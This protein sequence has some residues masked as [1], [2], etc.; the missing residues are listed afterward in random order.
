MRGKRSRPGA[1]QRPKFRDDFRVVGREWGLLLEHFV[2]GVICIL[3]ALVMVVA[4]FREP[5]F[6]AASGPGNSLS[7]FHDD[8]QYNRYEE[9]SCGTA[10]QIWYFWLVTADKTFVVTSE[11]H[12]IPT[13]WVQEGCIWTIVGGVLAGTLELVWIAG[14]SVVGAS[15]CIRGFVAATRLC[16]K[17]SREPKAVRRLVR[18]AYEGNVNAASALLNEMTPTPCP[19]STEANA[20]KAMVNRRDAYGRT[21]IWAAAVGQ[22]CNSAEVARLLLKHGADPNSVVA[23]VTPLTVACYHKNLPLVQLL[24]ENGACPHGLSWR[25]HFQP[26]Y[27]ALSGSRLTASGWFVV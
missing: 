9:A 14:F 11:N 13:A 16:I 12:S 1:M 19:E 23:N 17:L 4:I 2:P 3:L 27:R 6:V 7:N 15:A 26:L 25:I 24:L 21:A 22:S 10:L 5:D 18:A 20:V 8:G